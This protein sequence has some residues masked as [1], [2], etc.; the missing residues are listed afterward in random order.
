LTADV[1]K[2]T[3]QFDCSRRSAARKR[4]FYLGVGESWE[5]I[6]QKTVPE[7][8]GHR[9]GIEDKGFTG[10]LIRF[11]VTYVYAALT[12]LDM[13]WIFRILHHGIAAK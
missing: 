7:N 8:K 12:L 5:F 10:T 2:K 11:L 3:A 1:I 13:I 6:G 4:G 9:R